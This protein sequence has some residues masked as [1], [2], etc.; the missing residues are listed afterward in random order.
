MQPM[1]RTVGLSIDPEQRTWDGATK[2]L[3]LA[4][5][6][7]EGS[8]KPWHYRINP[9]ASASAGRPTISPPVV[10]LLSLCGVF[11]NTVK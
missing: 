2:T 10:L 7:P 11:G 6:S 9:K 3:G 8:G 1:Q 5:V 4:T